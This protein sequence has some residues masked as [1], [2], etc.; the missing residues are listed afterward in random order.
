MPL[1]NFGDPITLGVHPV[2]RSVVLCDAAA[3]KKNLGLGA[4]THPAIVQA[5]GGANPTRYH[6]RGCNITEGGELFILNKFS[7]EVGGEILQSEQDS[8]DAN[9]KQRRVGVG[10]SFNWYLDSKPVL[11]DSGS[12]DGGL[13]LCKKDAEPTGWADPESAG[14]PHDKGSQMLGLARNDGAHYAVL[15]VGSDG[16]LHADVDNTDHTVDVTPV[17]QI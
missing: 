13:F 4:H 1:G 14:L 10:H 16:L 15:F 5:E 6:L 9:I 2:T 8:G 3:V 7:A 17:G 11:W 12:N